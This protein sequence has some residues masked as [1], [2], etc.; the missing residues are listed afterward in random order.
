MNPR[1]SAAQPPSASSHSRRDFLQRSAAAIGSAAVAG[2]FGAFLSRSARAAVRSSSP[3]YGPLMP[4]EDG[5][6]GIPLL[7]LPEGFR[8]LSYGWTGEPM[9]DGTKTPGAHDGMA[10]IAEANG[11]LTIC[12]NHEV[13][14][15]G[16]PFGAKEI[17]FDGRAMG[18]TSNLEFDAAKGE[19][20]SSRP[21]LAGTLKNCAGGP[22]PWGSW[23]SC[24]ETVLSPGDKDDDRVWELDHEHGWIFEVPAEGSA[25]AIALKD[26]GRFV[27]EAIAVDPETG[28]VYETEDRGTAGFYRFEPKVAGDLAQGGGLSMLKVPRRPDVRKGLKVGDEFDVTWVPIA[29][30][31]RAHSPGTT[32][33]LGVYHQ[34]KAEDATTFA[35]LEGCWYGNQR[36]YLVSTSGGDARQGQIWEYHPQT[37]RLKLLF[38][39]PGADVLDSP[40]NVTVSPRGG[41]VLCEDGD[42]EPQRMHGLTPDGRLFPF[43]A[44]NVVLNGEHNG[45]T[46]DF[47]GSEWAGATFSPD[48]EW[49]FAN[50]QRP[51]ITFAITGPWKDGG[52]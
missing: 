25:R 7:Q 41:I 50:L 10:V 36:I 38:E 22:T 11:R 40:D 44:S 8:Y 27:H 14:R 1:P 42:Q 47:R 20:L 23:L 21:S 13:R 31:Y 9:S 34:G 51:G 48:G 35:R 37:E 2:A 29:D 12:R 39:S 43:A 16:Q 30:P 45:I 4:I 49:L 3:A 26:M 28:F 52:L 18:G 15:V 6:T 46:G 5:T 33:Q 32:D 24:E 19:W 17:T